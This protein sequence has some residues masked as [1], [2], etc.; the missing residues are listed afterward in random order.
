[1]S[2]PIYRFASYKHYSFVCSISGFALIDNG[3]ADPNQSQD[4]FAA[5]VFLLPLENPLDVANNQAVDA[6]TN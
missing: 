3:N 2:P 6:V 5:E 1:M 4:L